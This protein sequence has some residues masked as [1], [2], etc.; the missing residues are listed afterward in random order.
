M[1]RVFLRA[2]LA[3][4][5]LVSPC[6]A[7]PKTTAPANAAQ[8]PAPL[9]FWAPRHRSAESAY[10]AALL[11]APSADR[12]RGFHDM[13]ASEPHVAGTPGDARVIDAIERTFKSMGLE[14]E[15]HELWLDLCRPDDAAIEIIAPEHVVLPLRE[16]PV[17]GDPLT[18]RPDLPI[19]WNAYSGSGDVT[20][21][22]VYANYGRKEDFERLKELGVDTAGKIVI[23]RY[24]GNFRGYKAKF[25]E[26]AGAAALIIYTDPA[27]AGYVQGLVY[28]EGGFANGSAIQ[29]GSILTVPWGGDPLTPFEPATEGAKRL[30]PAEVPFPKIPVQPIGWSA[31]Q[32]I[33]SRMTGAAAPVGEGPRSWQGGLPFT[34]RLTGGDDLRVRVMVKQT[35]AIMRT[36][37]V[38]A[39]LPGADHPEEKVIF[40]CHH[41]AWVCGAQDPTSGTILVLEA[42]RCLSDAAKQGRRPARSVVFAAWG[43]EE[44]GILGSGEWV[45]A[46]RADLAHNA[47]AYI[48]CDAATF[49]V[50]FSASASPSLKPLIAEVASAVYTGP[51]SVQPTA[52]G[53]PPT[54]GADEAP[55]PIVTA[56]VGNMG[57]G[58]DHVGF[59]CHVG[60]PSA[61]IGASGARGNAYHS[62]YDD[63]MWYRKVVGD[64]YEPAVLL[65]RVANLLL[66]RLANADLLPLDPAEP[67]MELTLHLDTA[68]ARARQL[69]MTLDI[70]DLRTAAAAVEERGRLVAE[71]LVRGVEGGGVPPDRLET[72][73]RA[74]MAMARCWIDPQGL[75]GRPWYRNIYAAPDEDS[76]YAPWMVP[77]LRRAVERRDEAA[78]AQAQ[79]DLGAALRAVEAQFDT[80]DAALKRPGDGR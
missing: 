56:R 22:V 47:V 72:I 16:D 77:A 32:Q 69:G 71:R 19:G 36:A 63:L 27:D 52:P 23:A 15:R 79:R 73:N 49:G 9:R 29:R 4:A 70:T 48:N 25:A 45:E 8:P 80:I 39:T 58:S 43:A 31:A 53:E 24:G 38:I 35:R 64:D 55:P 44:F 75:P 13:L 10:E 20:S 57:G 30:D 78:A 50:R 42:A 6:I 34:Y 74:L 5:L 37:N 3:A 14:V 41:D 12:L 46:H 28:P 11:A 40:G 60:V 67:A 59:L 1:N 65:T 33:L 7:Q 68:A 62:V 26:A 18:Q 76:G 2:V 17:A 51:D 54:A 61:G 66:A 21:T